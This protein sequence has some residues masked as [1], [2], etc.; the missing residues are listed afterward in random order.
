MVK[1]NPKSKRDMEN[2]VRKFGFEPDLITIG[3]YWDSELSYDE[4]RN[5]IETFLKNFGKDTLRVSEEKYQKDEVEALERQQKED[6]M[7]KIK[8]ELKKR[9]EQ[10]LKDLKNS[11]DINI[12]Y[13]EMF[14][15]IDLLLKSPDFNLLIV[16][17]ESASG[18][19]WQIKKYLDG[20]GV[21]FVCFNGHIT[22]FQCYQLLYHHNDKLLVFDDSNPIL[23][24]VSS[25][26]LLLQ[27]CETIKKRKVMWNSSRNITGVPDEFPFDGKV[28][29][30]TN[31]NLDELD[32]ALL[33]RG[34][35]TSVNFDN[36][37]MLKIINAIET[38]LSKEEKDR[39]M[40]IL[41]NNLYNTRINLRV[42]KLLETLFRIL[43]GRNNLG[44]FEKL[45][46]FLIEVESNENLK[47][48]YELLKDTRDLKKA[49][50]SFREETGLT[51][52]SFYYY[53][54]K[55]EEVF[56]TLKDCELSGLSNGKKT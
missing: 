14:S 48:V 6:E 42:W 37:T 16:S 53:K 30:I 44:E 35:K 9:A 41:K 4:N 47:I 7:V 21:K 46:N 12:Y 50:N 23:E 24:N 49:I 17:G 29:V 45:G 11:S 43:K 54:K 34:I 51:R 2:L 28:I 10:E 55:V 13:N 40:N 26:S 15:N 20:N 19:T 32:E 27:A 52:Q 3:D 33:T 56:F 1:L 31:K 5:I 18:K 8:F 36:F 38:D 22:P 39:I 25:V